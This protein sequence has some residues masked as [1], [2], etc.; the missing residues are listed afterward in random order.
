MWMAPGGLMML[1]FAPISSRLMSGIGAR[2][3]LVIGAVILGCGYLIAVFLTGSSWQLMVAT[4]VSM[5][6]VGIG[7]AAMP[8][9]I[10]Q[11]VPVT[12]A[13]SAVGINGLMRA[14]GT[15]LATA[16]MTAVLT[17]STVSFGGFAIPSET[18]FKMC[19]VIGAAAAF[20]GAAL[21]LLVGR[22]TRSPVS[23]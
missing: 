1:V 22:P 11:S 18:A 7:Y 19:F 4:C 23:D 13:G 14:I 12:E 20:V 5:A 9:L 10:L 3:T 2:L 8:T 6:G 17:S 21:A 15:S 16:V